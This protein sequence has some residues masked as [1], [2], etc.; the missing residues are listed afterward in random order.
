M[1]LFCGTPVASAAM[2]SASSCAAACAIRLKAMK[3]ADAQNRS[4]LLSARQIEPLLLF[5]LKR[6]ILAQT[7]QR[8][9]A[10]SVSKKRGSAHADPHRLGGPAPNRAQRLFLTPIVRQPPDCSP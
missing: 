10:P 2:L 5:I 6:A 9:K 7:V 4:G 3:S 1:T 8:K